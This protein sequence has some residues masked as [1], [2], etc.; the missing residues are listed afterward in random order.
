MTLNGAVYLVDTVAWEFGPQR[1]VTTG[2]IERS[3]YRVTVYLEEVSEE[4]SR[5][6][7]LPS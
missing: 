2:I 6:A 3:R 7:E 4:D 1:H 5:P